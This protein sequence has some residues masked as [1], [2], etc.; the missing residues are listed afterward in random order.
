MNQ[1]S[2]MN[3]HEY[4]TP[5]SDHT[6]RV[7]VCP[8]RLIRGVRRWL[9]DNG[10]VCAFD[11]SLSELCTLPLSTL[12]V[13]GLHYYRYLVPGCF[14]PAGVD[15]AR[16]LQG[17]RKWLE[18]GQDPPRINPLQSRGFPNINTVE[19]RVGRS[20]FICPII[21]WLQRKNRAARPGRGQISY[22]HAVVLT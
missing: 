20:N 4:R 12:A 21:V 3:L 10:I 14:I 11:H 5:L 1:T 16:C 13:L 2:P 22:A 19:A 18:R 15:R 6:N 8:A 9:L 7:S 17:Q